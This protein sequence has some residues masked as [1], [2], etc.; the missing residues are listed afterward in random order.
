MD[1]V[2]EGRNLYKQKY[3]VKKM[4]EQLKHRHNYCK[5]IKAAI[6]FSANDYG[7]K[8]DKWHVMNYFK[9]DDNVMPTILEFN[10]GFNDKND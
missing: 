6:W 3:W 9:L 4:F 2:K 10:K 5:N 7:F 1:Y 8:D